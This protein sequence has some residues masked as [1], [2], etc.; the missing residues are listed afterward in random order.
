[1]LL[2]RKQ[3]KISRNVLVLIILFLNLQLPAQ[4]KNTTPTNF[5]EI[6]FEHLGAEQGLSKSDVFC[7]LQDQN[8]FMW[9]GTGDGLNKYD[10]YK[11]TIYRNDPNDSLSLGNNFI[12]ALYEDHV[13]ELWIGTLRGGLCK[14]D[15]DSDSFIRYVYDKENP[16]SL[17]GDLIL[18]IFE[19]EEKN[20]HILWIG[21]RRGGLCRYDP[22]KDSFIR[23]VYDKENP[24]SLCSDQIVSIFESEKN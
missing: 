21:T 4:N 5:P 15:P 10:G 9:F 2:V 7:I 17:C 23:Y 13:G 14:Y 1:M 12:T 24:N 19:S 3:Y 8:G 11:F 20:Q 16:N 22:D 6:K 18:S